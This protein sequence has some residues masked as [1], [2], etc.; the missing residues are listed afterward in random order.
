MDQ[1][2]A[3]QR[4]PE[5]RRAP[6]YAVSAPVQVSEPVSGQCVAGSTTVIMPHPLDVEYDAEWTRHYGNNSDCPR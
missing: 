4:L 6:R 1:L 3:G 2:T 5:S